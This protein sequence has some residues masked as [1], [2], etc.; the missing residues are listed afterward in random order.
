MGKDSIKKR[1][2]RAKRKNREDSKKQ[3]KAQGSN[4]G[5]FEGVLSA[6]DSNSAYSNM[7]GQLVDLFSSYDP[8]EIVLSLCVSDLW[9]SNISSPIRHQIAYRTLASMDDAEFKSSSRIDSYTNFSEFLKRFYDLVSHNPMLEDYIPEQDWG[10]IKVNFENRVFRLFYGGCVERIPDFIEAFKITSSDNPQA[11]DDLFFVLEVQNHLLE[12]ID[13]PELKDI[14][15]GHVE[16]PDECFW[17]QAR[18]AI[19][20]C[21]EYINEN[22]GYESRS[23]LF[24]SLGEVKAVSNYNEIGDLALT[25]KLFRYCGLNLDGRYYL[26]S[27]RNITSVVIDIWSDIDSDGV[28]EKPSVINAFNDF[29]N[30]RHK[31]DCIF[32][33]PFALFKS[34]EPYECVF[35]T[36][37]QSESENYLVLLVDMDSVEEGV[38]TKSDIINFLNGEKEW[39]LINLRNKEIFSLKSLSGEFLPIEELNLICV[40]C[41]SS[42][43]HKL[44]GLKEDSCNLFFLSDF[45]TVFD[46]IKDLSEFP[47]FIK[48][49]DI[50]SR[51]M[52]GGMTGSADM[53]ASFRDSDEVLVA[54][55]NEFDFVM[56]DAS[57]GSNWRFVMLKE[58][59]EKIPD[60]VPNDYNLWERLESDNDSLYRM[61]ARN[62]TQFSWTASVN[63]TT[64]HFVF[65][66]QGI[67]S[68][69][70]N[71]YLIE[72]ACH[73]F[74]DSILQRFNMLGHLPIF[75]YKN[76]TIYCAS[77][78]YNLAK[79]DESEFTDKDSDI[80]SGCQL[81]R[82]DGD[83]VEA[84]FEVNLNCVQSNIFNATTSLF[85]YKSSI[86]FCTKFS[87]LLG[88]DSLSISSDSDLFQTSKG[89]PRFRQGVYIRD[90]DIPDRHDAKLP[91]RRH[92]KLARKHL[93][94]IFKELGML[95][96]RYELQEAKL[97]IDQA[98]EEYQ[99]I[100]HDEI[101]QYRRSP[102]LR[103]CICQID[104]LSA[105]YD[106][107]VEKGR[108]SLNHEVDY[109]RAIDLSAA[110]EEFSRNSKN[111]RYLLE[112]RLYY[113][114][115][116]GKNISHESISL[117]L[118]NIDWLFVL[119][120]ASDTL[121]NGID[122]GGLELDEDF[123]PSVFYSEARGEKEEEYTRV[124]AS[125]T[126]GVNHVKTDSLVFEPNEK[127]NWDTFNDAFVKDLSF[128][129]KDML[130]IMSLLAK[131]GTYGNA[132]KF[133]WYYEAEKEIIVLV[134]NKELP[135]IDGRVVEAILEFLILR[136]NSVRTLLG[137][138]GVEES[139]VPV[140][141]HFNRGG[142][143]TIRPIVEISDE[144]LIWGAASVDKALRIWTGNVA[145]GYLPANFE[146]GN[147]KNEVNKIKT[148]LEKALESKAF[149]VIKRHTKY[150]CKSMDFRRKFKSENFDDVGD[151]DGLVYFPEVNTWV[152]FE[153]KYNQP[154]FCIKDSRRLRDLIFIKNKSHVS[155]IEKRSNFLKKHT[156][157]IRSLLGWPES[158]CG[159]S[160]RY[161]NVY[162]S[163]E[164]FWWM[165]NPP[166][167]TDI[168][169]VKIDLLDSWLSTFIENVL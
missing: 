93:S 161:I 141:D 69:P 160:P 144:K 153:C 40:L 91:S 8:E 151:F 42:S 102:L 84:D 63:E 75:N 169:F 95:P 128:S 126:L 72:T 100:I 21:E 51:T 18:E 24:P 20:A 4:L 43:S 97:L 37:I 167:S 99:L 108:Q 50:N 113:T 64:L 119:L 48:Y 164:A 1:Q 88:L 39:G 78:I 14:G 129:F 80:F 56:L 132:N 83:R 28:S 61:K 33:G 146:W 104:A 140:W 77:D 110:H 15:I 66:F 57:T 3:K 54:G 17:N 111:Y 118:A 47:R 103:Y 122:V 123:V 86:E 81:V 158:E 2:R 147:V 120:G 149:E 138:N 136:P 139:D 74:S 107:K 130:E 90:Y 26:S 125:N 55:A 9:L 79:N 46:S 133:D 114:E 115:E 157:K 82:V 98:R 65:D 32:D 89:L 94:V 106:T 19:L 23:R 121:H 109:D 131:W 137:R 68:D 145:S 166:S 96:G 152:A 155:K 62:D 112:N 12:S 117:C 87:A 53:F 6:R 38:N 67:E 163:R 150:N 25:G 154:P 45:L 70:E 59:W 16:V 34:G 5:L 44:I 135:D 31:A 142:R 13:P 162:V 22:I 76:I 124:M 165:V 105:D 58:Y 73:C 7:L 156:E 41:D 52:M 71:A 60:N 27:P 134:A 168:E 116:G 30:I 29:L 159:E 85:E 143:Y 10:E 49:L 11:M 101:S 35:S 148:F 36:L 92:Y 127:V